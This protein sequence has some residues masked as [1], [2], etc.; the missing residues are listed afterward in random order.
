MW[1]PNKPS[2]WLLLV[3]VVL[4]LV[5][6]FGLLTWGRVHDALEALAGNPA[7]AQVFHAKVDRADAIFMVFMF[8]MLT[9][10]AV[11]AAVGLIAFAGAVLAGFLESLL[12]TP[13]MPDWVF[14]GFVYLTLI[15][16]GVFTRKVW[17]PEM[18]GFFGLIARAVFAALT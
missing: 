6:Y 9:P 4:F 12:R 17:L 8:L 7:G 13:G 15:V 16:I 18:Q 10:L 14:T 11:V 2:H 1:T 3:L 5:T